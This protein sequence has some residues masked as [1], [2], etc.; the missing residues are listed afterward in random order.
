MR[1]NFCKSRHVAGCFAKNRHV[2]FSG[3]GLEKEHMMF[4][5]SRCLKNHV[6]VGKDINI[7]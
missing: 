2:C 7:F 1:G 4:C 3:D 6:I 5:Y